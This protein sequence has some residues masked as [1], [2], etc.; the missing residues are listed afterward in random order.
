MS[1]SIWFEQVNKGL[2]AEI[3][4]TV[5]VMDSSGALVSLPEKSV[6]VRKPED[7]FKVEMFPCVSIYNLSLIHI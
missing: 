7:E 2:I 1:R 5:K 4:N 3:L 6:T